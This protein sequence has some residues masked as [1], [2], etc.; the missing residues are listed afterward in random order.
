MGSKRK[1]QG[2]GGKQKFQGR[3]LSGMNSIHGILFTC[4]SDR[5]REARREAYS[6]IEEVNYSIRAN[7]IGC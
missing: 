1:G 2:G 5:E 3:S 7:R 6:L 4:P